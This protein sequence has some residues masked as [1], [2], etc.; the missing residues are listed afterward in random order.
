MYFC[1][2][3][4]NQFIASALLTHTHFS[5]VAVPVID[6]IVYGKELDNVIK[7]LHSIGTFAQNLSSS[8]I[9]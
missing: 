8:Y 4:Y 1:D 7:C 9:W 2:S 6:L 3:M 5:M